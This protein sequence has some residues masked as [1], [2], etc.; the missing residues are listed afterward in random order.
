MTKEDHTEPSL[1]KG[2]VRKMGGI[3]HTAVHNGT[4]ISIGHNLRVRSITDKEEHIDPNGEHE[5]WHHEDIKV[6]YEKLFGQAIRDY[7]A[8]QKRKDRRLDENYIKTIQEDE[9]KHVMYE[10][11][12]GVYP[13]DGT[14]CPDWLQKA[15]LKEYVDAW[16]KENPNLYMVGAYFHADEPD[17]GMHVHIDYVPVGHFKNYGMEVQNSLT[18]ALKE[19]GLTLQKADKSKDQEWRTAQMQLQD[20][21]RGRLDVLCQEH[22]LDVEH[23]VIEGKIEAKE[24]LET[25]QYKAEKHL[26]STIDHYVSM[27]RLADEQM[28]RAEKA[29]AKAQKAVE[30]AGRAQDAEQKALEHKKALTTEIKALKGDYDEQIGIQART[31]GKTLL[32]KPKKKIELDY[33]EYQALNARANAVT[34]LQSGQQ[35]LQRDVRELEKLRQK[36]FQERELAEKK[37][38]EAIDRH[39]SLESREKNVEREVEKILTTERTATEKA[40]RAYMKDFTVNGRNMLE[41]FD[42][43]EK[44]RRLERQRS[45]GWER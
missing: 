20:K 43:K 27:E 41:V 9:Y 32:G 3:V 44:Q 40:M 45:R 26:E 25:E 33:T 36:V 24:H 4:Q 34:D 42:E 10:C 23:P 18:R 28:H 37:M 21:E 11:I 38:K 6:A 17:A 29:D 7:N 22:G 13:Q 35:A 31:A 2:K 8:K 30:R 19:Q 5:T 14:D 16:Q 1:E 39:V 12:V 15:I